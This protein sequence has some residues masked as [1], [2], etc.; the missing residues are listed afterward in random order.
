MLVILCV[1]VCVLFCHRLS[2]GESMSNVMVLLVNTW[3]IKS[4]VLNEKMYQ[5]TWV[6]C[7]TGSNWR[8][9]FLI[10]QYF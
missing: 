10:M 3:D 9:S 8:I 2:P 1:C 6:S 7:Y 4:E 5:N